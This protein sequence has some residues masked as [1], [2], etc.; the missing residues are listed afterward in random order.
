[1]RQVNSSV[2]AA[3]IILLA[4]HK[5]KAQCGVAS[6]K[7]GKPRSGVIYLVFPSVYAPD[8]SSAAAKAANELVDALSVG[9]AAL[10]PR[11]KACRRFATLIG[12]S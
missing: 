7:I 4:P 8:A 5:P 3:D 6:K 10:H 2:R 9:S 1:M 12:L 11:L